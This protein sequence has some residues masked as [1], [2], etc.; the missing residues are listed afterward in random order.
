MGD[1]L[2][3][4]NEKAPRSVPARG[5]SPSLL[6][7]LFFFAVIIVGLLRLFIRGLAK[8]SRFTTAN[9]VSFSVLGDDF[10]LIVATRR[11]CLHI[12]VTKSLLRFKRNSFT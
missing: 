8:S 4:I 11:K 5:N 10:P 12:L 3:T 6:P 1:N 9:L 2:S 7:T